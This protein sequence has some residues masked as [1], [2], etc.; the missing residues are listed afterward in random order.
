MEALA[1]FFKSQEFINVQPPI[2]TSSDCE[3]G[4][5][6]FQVLTSSPSKQ[7]DHFFNRP[8][9]TTV[10]SQLHLEFLA[11]GMSRVYTIGPC[12]RAEPSNSTRHLAEFWM[13][14]AEIAFI[15]DLDHLVDFIEA[16]I[17]FVIKYLLDYHAED[18]QFFNQ[19][20]EKGLV[21]KLT[22]MVD[23]P[24]ARITYTDA[25]DALLKVKDKEWR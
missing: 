25:I 2:L 17:K 10:S 23:E 13:L 7:D 21:E 5:E 6:A 9:F 19:F 20:I 18:L 14:E 22:K 8:V 11:S 4:G 12:F 15:T 1:Q 16:Q 3:G 24:F